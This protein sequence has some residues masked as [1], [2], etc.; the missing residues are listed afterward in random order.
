MWRYNDV[1]TDTIPRGVL[2]DYIDGNFMP[3]SLITLPSESNPV[4]QGR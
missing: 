1:D 2:Y 3:K 4:H